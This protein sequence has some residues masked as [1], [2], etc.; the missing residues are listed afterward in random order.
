MPDITEPPTPPLAVR[1]AWFFGIAAGSAGLVAIVA[2]AL[3]A[4]LR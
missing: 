3:R 1:L 4:L 2:Y